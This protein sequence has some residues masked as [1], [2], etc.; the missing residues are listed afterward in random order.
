MVLRRPLTNAASDQDL[1]GLPA[2]PVSEPFT[3]EEL[4]RDFLAVSDWGTALWLSLA[5]EDFFSAVEGTWS[6]ADHLRHLIKSNRPVARALELPRP[7]LLLRFGFTRR[8]S[9]SY[10]AMCATY[11]EALGAGLQAGRFTPS[12]L[13]SARH[14]GA[15]R[16]RALEQWSDTLTT[17]RL[18]T[19]KWSEGALSRLRLP[20]PGL[21]LLTVREMLFFTL[22][23]NTHHVLGVAT[24]RRR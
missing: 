4:A 5:P 15:E 3:G 16:A 1:A 17:L 12:P 8:A 22:Y 19:R 11:R 24:R 2:A 14:T 7:V 10:S 21:G 18:A 23:H 6:P 9:R 13:P 20:H